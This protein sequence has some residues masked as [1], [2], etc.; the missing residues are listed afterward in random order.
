MCILSSIHVPF[1]FPQK[2]TVTTRSPTMTKYIAIIG[3]CEHT[4]Y[5]LSAFSVL[6]IELSNGLPTIPSNVL[7][8]HQYSHIQWQ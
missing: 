3:S 7:E 4:T 2:R 8:N 1:A 6:I 5:S